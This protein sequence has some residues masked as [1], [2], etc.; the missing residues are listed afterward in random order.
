M[1][2]ITREKERAIAHLLYRE[3]VKLLLNDEFR[4][5]HEGTR[6]HFQIEGDI[7]NWGCERNDLTLDPTIMQEEGIPAIAEEVCRA[8]YLLIGFIK[9]R[10]PS[11]KE[12][13]ELIGAFLTLAR[14]ECKY[15]RTEESII[16]ACKTEAAFIEAL[17]ADKAEL[18][19]WEE[20]RRS[21]PDGGYD[22]RILQYTRNEDQLLVEHRWGYW[23]CEGK[24]VEEVDHNYYSLE[25]WL[26]RR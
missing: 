4:F 8:Y 1:A 18:I 3:N 6:I 13:Q 23:N 21:R 24:F 7:V 2:Y 19:T 16:I 15:P 25:S 22:Y 10:D 14:I 17:V 9:G 26:A 5:G 20:L 11:F 12:R